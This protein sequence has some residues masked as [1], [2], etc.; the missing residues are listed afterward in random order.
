MSGTRPAAVAGMFYPGDASQLHADIQAMLSGVPAGKS[1]PKAIIVPHAGYVYS[2]PVAASAYNQLIP[3]RSTIKRVILLGPC[4]RVPLTGLATTSADYFETPL[5]LIPIDRDSISVINSLQ[6]V[7]EFDLT[8]QQEHS[9]E[10]QL[11][12]LQEVLDEFTLVP[13][14]VGDTTA[15]DIHEVLEML[16]GGDETLIVIS[17]DLSHYHDYL[18]AQSMDSLTCQAIE[19]LDGGAIQYEQACGRNPVLGLLHA[20]QRHKM[21]VTT[22]DLRNSGDTAGSKDQVVGYGAWMFEE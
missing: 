13:L 3:S 16:W 18:T 17:S 21:K 4:H 19:N 6:Q 1:A 12:F 14:V 9:L 20:A 22:L 11:P 2:G 8:H 15:E 5:G 10:V 7:V